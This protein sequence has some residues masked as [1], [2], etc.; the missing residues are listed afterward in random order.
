VRNGKAFIAEAVESVRDQT[1]QDFEIV[2]VNDHS[3]DGT[4]E[5]LQ[6]YDCDPRVRIMDSEGLGLSRALNT[7][8]DSARGRFIARL[9]ADD[10][11]HPRRLEKQVAKMQQDPDLFLVGSQVRRCDEQLKPL[12]E[13]Q[14][15][16]DHRPIVQAL[17]RGHHGMAHTTIMFR[18]TG[19]RYEERPAEDYAFFLSAARNGR[20][21]NLPE[22]LVDYRFHGRSIIATKLAAHQRDMLSVIDRYLGRQP[23]WKLV[24]EIRIRR[25]CVALA[26]Y[27]NTQVHA[28][29]T[30]IGVAIRLVGASILYPSIA[31]ERINRISST[32]FATRLNR[33]R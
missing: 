21:A 28:R 1:F 17:V 33:F 16:L 4:V 15:P 19:I 12:S 13:S 31:I 3:T 9:D 22:A 14:L 26:I 8:L 25:Q 29:Y 30:R 20:L 24:R 7:G 27:R 23:R 2:V 11:A 6:R 10:S 32:Y 5:L 18:N